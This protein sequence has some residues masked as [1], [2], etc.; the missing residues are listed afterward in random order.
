[1]FY[2]YLSHVCEIAAKSIRCNRAIYELNLLSD[3]EL[4]ALGITRGEIYRT[5]Y[6]SMV[7]SDK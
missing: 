7:N 4:N 3:H 2:N 5:V 1:M 6:M